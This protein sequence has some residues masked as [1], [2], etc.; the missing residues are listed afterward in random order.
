MF[1]APRRPKPATVELHSVSGI[2]LCLALLGVCVLLPGCA[3]PGS[4][5]PTVKIGLSAP[6]EG[7]YRDLGYE[8]LYAVRLA[9][10]QRN[11]AGGID[12]RYL[13]E[14]VALNDFDEPD[15]AVLQAQKMSVDPGVLG[16]LGGW[17]AAT[18]R[19]AVPVYDRLG[20]AFLSPPVDYS[21]PQPFAPGDPDF[22]P[23]YRELSA[24]AAP[25]PAAI[26]AYDSAN[27][28]LDALDLAASSEGRPTRPGV[29]KALSR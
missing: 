16:V 2:R 28:L 6:F 10:G 11:Q 29:L 19:A 23:A 22:G 18:A 26:W 21:L 5:K 3:F 9:V 1:Q 17:S 12:G 13:V 25:G 15:E 24:G 14:F 20:L 8:V 4:V 7:R 27:R